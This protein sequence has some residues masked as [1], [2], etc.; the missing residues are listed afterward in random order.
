VDTSTRSL[1]AHRFA[2]RCGDRWQSEAIL[3]QGLGEASRI[4]VGSPGYGLLTD[5]GS[6]RGVQVYDLD[7]A[8]IGGASCP[9]LRPKWSL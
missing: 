4:P 5:G 3:G 6:L 1:L 7:H 9:G 8:L 2:L